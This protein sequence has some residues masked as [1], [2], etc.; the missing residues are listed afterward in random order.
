MQT[1]ITFIL[2]FGVIVIVHEFGHFYF[3]KKSGV[4]VREFAIGMGPK[5]FQTQRNGTTYTLR[6][7]PVGGYVRMAS[8]AEAEENPLQPGMTVMLGVVD[9]VVEKINLAEQVEIIGGRAFTVNDF[10]LVDA[11]FIEGYFEN[12]ETLTRLPV[13]H[14]ASM[15]E[16]DGTELLIAPRDTQFESAKLWQRAL[17]N[18]AGPLNNFLLTIVLFTGVAFAMP[19]VTTTTLDEVQS[20]SPA[21]QAGLKSGDDIKS[22][23]GKKVRSWQD[24]QTMVQGSSAASLKMTYERNSKTQTVTVKP[25]AKEIQG[26]K[27]RQIGVTPELTKAPGARLNYAWQVTKQSATQIWRAIIGL[28]QSFSLNKLGGPVAIYK[29]TEQVSSY[30]LISVISFTAM[31][32]INLGMM[33]L[34]PIPALDGGK[35]LLNLIEAIFRRPISEKVEMTVTIAGAAL[36]VVLMIAVTGNDLFRYFIK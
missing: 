9:G 28:F 10:D 35:L 18:F 36:L 20:N 2:V 25:Q 3:A 1:L 6:I 27:V 32:S 17:I 14:D 12:E 30:G 13:D 26:Q 34:L 31:L 24:M 5:L 15:I 33:N 19:G 4:R 21:L 11:L 22:I 7:L 16:S 8:R 29:N 23:D